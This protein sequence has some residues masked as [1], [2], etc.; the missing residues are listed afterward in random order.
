MS[1]VV[2]NYAQWV[3]RYPEFAGVSE[4]MAGFYFTEATLYLNNTDASIVQ[5][6]ATRALLLNM[7][8]AHIAK[9]NATIAGIPPSGLVGRVSNAAEGSVS[10]ATQMAVPGSAE[11]YAQTTYGIAF[12]AATARYRTMRWQVSTK[13][14]PFYVANGRIF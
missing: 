7:L 5:D 10:V 3:A 11:W 1:V 12:W 4:E 9:L 13:P 14:S 6:E 2:F 8:V